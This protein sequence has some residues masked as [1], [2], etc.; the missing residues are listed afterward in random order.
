M[1]NKQNDYYD[2]YTRAEIAQL[3]GISPQAVSKRL[4]KGKWPGAKKFGNCWMIPVINGFMI[5][6]KANK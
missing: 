6:F 3:L 2:Y 5:P 1:S 4:A